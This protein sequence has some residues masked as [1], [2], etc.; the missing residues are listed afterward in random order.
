MLPKRYLKANHGTEIPG[1]LLFFDTESEE[2]LTANGG[3]KKILRLRLWKAI[4]IRFDGRRISRRQVGSGHTPEEFWAFLE[5]RIQRGQPLWAFAHNLNFDLTMLHFWKELEGGRYRHLA[6]PDDGSPHGQNRKK[7]FRGKLCVESNPMFLYLMAHNGPVRFVDTANYWPKKLAE[8]GDKLGV[9]KMTMPNWS[10]PEDLW[11]AYCEND[12]LVLEA[13]VTDLLRRWKSEDCGVFR[14]TAPALAMQNFRH[15]C[16]IRTPAG[17]ALDLVLDQSH[18]SIPQERRSYFGGR[19]EPFFLGK[20]TGTIYHLDVNSLYPAV[21]QS[22]HF[23]RRRLKVLRKPSLRELSNAMTAYGCIADVTINSKWETFP[24]RHK[25]IQIHCRGF[26][27]TTLCGAELRR[28]VKSGC[29]EQCHKATTYCMVK[30]FENW[31]N[32]WFDRKLTA[33]AMG[34]K[35]AGELELCKLILNSLSGKWAQKGEFWETKDGKPLRPDWGQWVEYNADTGVMK[36]MRNVAGIAQEYVIGQEPEH[37]FPAI[38]AYITSYAREYMRDLF[39]LCP[40]K[41]I[42]YTATDSI[43]CDE[44]AFKAL[45]DAHRVHETGLGLLKVKGIHQ[46][47]EIFGPN[48]YRLDDQL[49]RSGSW[50]KMKPH[51]SGGWFFESWQ[52]IGETIA[53]RPDGTISI[54]ECMLRNSTPTKKGKTQPDGWVDPYFVTKDDEFTDHLPVRP[55]MS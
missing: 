3:R 29:V 31:V 28:A 12:C 21:M 5:S 26:F 14:P 32:V 35:G 39:A 48:H 22:M 47:C 1:N 52:R 36:R 50:A 18:E 51:P 27:R 16:D 6:S 4:A 41:S 49:V 45:S 19:I 2:P 25:G 13:A 8:I 20:A 24:L 23:P 43:I 44:R 55:G 42:D 10:D 54:Q 11:F 15:T 46:E 33:Q 30:L 40:E 9:P 37:S 7:A 38:S 53:Q 34:A 17:D